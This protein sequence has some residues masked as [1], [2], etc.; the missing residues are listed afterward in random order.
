MNSNL[1]PFVFLIINVSL[2]S[3]EIQMF[4]IG[5]GIQNNACAWTI[6]KASVA[7]FDLSFKMCGLYAWWKTMYSQNCGVVRTEKYLW[8]LPGFTG[9]KTSVRILSLSIFNGMEW[10]FKDGKL[11][12]SFSLKLDQ[13][14]NLFL[15]QNILIVVYND[16]VYEFQTRI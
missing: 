14:I 12:S 4:I 2:K 1:Y 3:G 8:V 11:I 16:F 6:N 9:T 13:I 15:Y 10:I 5:R 7:I